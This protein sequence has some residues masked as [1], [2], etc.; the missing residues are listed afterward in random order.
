MVLSYNE[1]EVKDVSKRT[2]HAL[3]SRQDQ[4]GQNRSRFRQP[5]KLK[6]WRGSAY[7]RR[8]RGNTN[9]HPIPRKIFQL[10]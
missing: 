6:L 2:A 10:L 1:A 7:G 3:K 8:K 9:Q 5:G 4:Y